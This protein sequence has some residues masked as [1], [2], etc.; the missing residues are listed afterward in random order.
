MVTILEGDGKSFKFL[1]GTALKIKLCDQQNSKQQNIF[2]M[3]HSS[4][5][6]N[7]L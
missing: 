6:L 5:Y 2:L 7:W 3:R 4:F 1:L